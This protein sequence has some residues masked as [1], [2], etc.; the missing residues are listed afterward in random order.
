MGV[1]LGV[2]EILGLAAAGLL[3]G[4]AVILLEGVPVSVGMPD[5]V[6]DGEPRREEVRVEVAEG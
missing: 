2:G 3:V 1:T 5:G 4:V 6:G